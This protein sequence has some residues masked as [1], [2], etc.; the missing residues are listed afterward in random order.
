MHSD[1]DLEQIYFPS[2][3]LFSFL[4]TSLHQSLVNPSE[5]VT[6]W[7]ETDTSTGDHHACVHEMMYFSGTHNNWTVVGTIG[8]L[9]PSFPPFPLRNIKS[10]PNFHLITVKAS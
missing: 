2:P 4:V 3:I 10:R 9:T 5:A 7:L 6:S 8:C 1:S